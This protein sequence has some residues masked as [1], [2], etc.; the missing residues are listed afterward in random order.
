KVKNASTHFISPKGVILIKNFFGQTVGRIDIPPTTILAGTDRYLIDSKH[1]MADL[2]THDLARL[3]NTPTVIWP[4]KFL[5]G[6]YTATLSLS[7]SHGNVLYTRTIYFAA[8]PYTAILIILVLIYLSFL[9]VKRLR[10]K[11]AEV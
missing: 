4:E 1:A 6:F 2:S 5:F 9:F 10:K 8:F 3:N 11:L 7:L